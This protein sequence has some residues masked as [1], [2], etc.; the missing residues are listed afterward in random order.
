MEC[1]VL[2]TGALLPFA[3]FFDKCPGVREVSGLGIDGVIT[4]SDSYNEWVWLSPL[5]FLG[6]W[7][8]DVSI[9]KDLFN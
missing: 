3:T 8:L 2:S 7:E 9:L 4:A 1:Q 5:K 6:D